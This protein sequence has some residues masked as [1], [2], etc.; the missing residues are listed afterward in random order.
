LALTQSFVRI[1]IAHD[2]LFARRILPK[3]TKGQ[4][5]LWDIYNKGK[6]VETGKKPS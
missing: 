4:N 3:I 2:L 6:P 5:N 1:K